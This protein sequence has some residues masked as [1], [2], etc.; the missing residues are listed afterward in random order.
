MTAADKFTPSEYETLLR[1]DFVSF[2]QR[3]VRELSLILAHKSASDSHPRPPMAQVHGGVIRR[4]KG[5]P[6]REKSAALFVIPAKGRDRFT[7]W[8]PAGACPRAARR[9]DPW[10]G[11][12]RRVVLASNG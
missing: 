6:P 9:A 12:T 7:R 10:A 1:L 8:A 2:A 11:V 5:A 3:C 4:P